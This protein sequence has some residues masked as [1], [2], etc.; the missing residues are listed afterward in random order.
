ML[1]ADKK[2]AVVTVTVPKRPTDAQAK[3]VPIKKA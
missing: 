1:T 2:D 3:R